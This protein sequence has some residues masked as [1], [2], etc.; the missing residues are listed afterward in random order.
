[1][2]AQTISEKIL[3]AKSGGRALA[4]EVVVCDVDL[5]LGTD[6]SAPM[7]IGYFERMGGTH[8]HD[9]SRVVF[10]LDHY[11]PPSSSATRGFHDQVR[12]FAKKHGVRV[13]EVG[14]GI[15]HQIA[16]ER[17]LAHPGMLVVGADSHTVT[18][19]AV[20]AFATGVGSSDLAAAMLTGQ[21][22]FRVPRTIRVVLDGERAP[23]VSAKDI[24]L[25]LIS[26]LGAEGAEY[27]ALEFTG[28]AASTFSF[29]DRLVLSNLAVEAGAKAAVWQSDAVL[30]AHVAGFANDLSE[31]VFPDVDARYARDVV[32]D[33]ASI[34]PTVAMPHAPGN[35]VPIAL[36]PDTPIHMVFLGT[37]TGGRVADYHEALAVLER[38]GGKLANGV[39]LVVTPASSEVERQLA[40]D[41]TLVKLARMG[42]TITM[43][44]CGAC[45]GTSGVIPGDGMNVLS[46]ANRNFKAR[47]GNATASIYLASPAACAAAALTGRITDPRST[48]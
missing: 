36:A 27:H 8:V 37:C 41:G 10:A 5:V 12:A 4:G 33:V 25:V 48:V 40:A 11:A 43:P 46:T 45:C 6:A 18:C 3:S 26:T 20:N 16:V 42:A 32:I 44:G 14:E 30:D 21:L 29:D 2:T 47:M 34:T 22:W 17:G 35:V 7:A 13:F 23:G 19:G 39:Q 31:P 15:S 24:A 38:G 1:V 28:P 9:A